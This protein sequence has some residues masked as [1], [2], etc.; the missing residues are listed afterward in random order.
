MAATFSGRGKSFLDKSVGPDGR[1]KFGDRIGG[2]PEEMIG[3][4]ETLAEE[5]KFSKLTGQ[6]VLIPTPAEIQEFDL[7][8]PEQGGP[9]LL[10]AETFQPLREEF[11]ARRKAGIAKEAET[12]AARES[13]LERV[14][15]AEIAGEREVGTP[16]EEQQ[17]RAPITRRRSG[18][19]R[20]R[21]APGSTTGGGPSL[22]GL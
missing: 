19:R 22:L 7:K 9:I 16:S 12:K 17:K 15:D 14:I 11:Q 2:D 18:G 8:F 6:N 13:A 20:G 3:S 5:A 4:P 21:F 1:F 10:K